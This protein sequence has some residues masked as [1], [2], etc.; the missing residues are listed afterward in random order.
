LNTR[1]YL[2]IFLIATSIAIGTTASIA[3]PAFAKKDS[4]HD[5]L[6]KADNNIHENAPQND[7]TIHEGLCQ[8]GHSTDAL[9]DLNGGQ[10]GCDFPA[11]T[12]PGN[13]DGHHK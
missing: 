5:G 4:A 12:D 2:A 8:G 10:N 7:V 11:I 9:D 6:E 3:N 1:T 13:S